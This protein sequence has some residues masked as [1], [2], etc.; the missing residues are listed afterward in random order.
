MH[1]YSAILLQHNAAVFIPASGGKI[2]CQAIFY[3]IYIFNLIPM[4]IFVF[5]FIWWLI[6]AVLSL[7]GKGCMDFVTPICSWVTTDGIFQYVLRRLR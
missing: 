5:C 7:L 6:D 4:L 1:C 2:D 3:L